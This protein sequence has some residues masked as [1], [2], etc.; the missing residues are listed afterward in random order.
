MRLI[1][2]HSALRAVCAIFC[3]LGMW[4]NDP[5]IAKLEMLGSI[6]SHL[7]NHVITS[8]AIFDWVAILLII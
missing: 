7:A 6:V 2:A 8:W 5:F 1:H 4:E 3:C